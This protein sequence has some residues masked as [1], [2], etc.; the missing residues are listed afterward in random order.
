M[1]TENRTVV[2]K[3]LRVEGNEELLF[4][5]HKVLVWDNV[6]VL[7]MYITGGHTIVQMYM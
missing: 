5:G 2:S 1:E 4:N 6:K 3:G 7:E